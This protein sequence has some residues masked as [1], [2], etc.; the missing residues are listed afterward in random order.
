MS[1]E[2]EQSEKSK[3]ADNSGNANDPKILGV[4]SYSV[5]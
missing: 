2:R 5:L 3:N 4:V 1:I